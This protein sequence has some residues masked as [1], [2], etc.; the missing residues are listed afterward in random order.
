MSYNYVRR[1][2]IWMPDTLKADIESR[3]AVTLV[4]SVKRGGYGDDEEL[5]IYIIG[6][7]SPA[8]ALLLDIELS[9]YLIN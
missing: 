7:C 2:R 8:V 5:F 4:R 6:S 3:Y 9:D 1:A